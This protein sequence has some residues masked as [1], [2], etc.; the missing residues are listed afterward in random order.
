M[1]SAPQIVGRR[2][3]SGRRGAL[4]L[5]ALVALTLLGFLLLMGG[6]VFSRRKQLEYERLDRE[7]AL[8]ALESEWAIL[9]SSAGSDLGSREGAP[10]VGPEPWLAHVAS[11]RPRL[12]VRSGPF[13]D[14]AEV[15]L[16]ISCVPERRIV[17]SGFVR[18]RR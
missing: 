4:L 15:K 3:S 5:E 10:F 6:W 13:P 18:L 7:S 12:T 8:L 16:E 11:R 1:A 2:R 14:L 9:R 17:Q